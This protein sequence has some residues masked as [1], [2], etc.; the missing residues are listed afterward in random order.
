[1]SHLVASHVS[2][3]ELPVVSIIIPVYNDAERLARCLNC[4]ASQTYPR[5]CWEAIVVDNGSGESPREI[6]ERFAFCRF[7]EERTPGSYAA[8]N[9][10]VALARGEVLAFTDSDCQPLPDWLEQGVRCL[11][12][13]PECAFVGGHV[14]VFPANKNRPSAI[15]LFDMVFG[16]DQRTNVEQSKFALTANLF[17]RRA[18]FDRVGKFDDSLRSGGDAD[19]GQRATAMGLSGKYCPAATVRHPA[20]RRWGDLLRQTRRIA[21]GRVDR[22]RSNRYRYATL[23]FFKTLAKATVPDMGRMARAWQRLRERGYGIID[24]A[25]VALVILF[26]QYARL[27]EYARKLCGAKSER[28]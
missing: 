15:E 22:H 25:R 2:A 26:V 24:W 6:V 23:H 13:G 20:R 11:L 10:G 3:D 8:R 21:G 16:L 27:W 18:T 17:T 14:E 19:W 1:M 9:R 5:D 4:L 12:A 28:S 7:S